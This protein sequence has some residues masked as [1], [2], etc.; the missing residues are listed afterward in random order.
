MSVGSGNG[1]SSGGSE[2]TSDTD[3]S[4]ST[5][6][7]SGFMRRTQQQKWYYGTSTL[8]KSKDG[9]SIGNYG[10]RNAPL[11]EQPHNGYF[12]SGTATKIPGQF[13]RTPNEHYE[14]NTQ[15]DV[16]TVYDKW[17]EKMSVRKLAERWKLPP[18]AVVQWLQGTKNSQMLKCPKRGA[19]SILGS[20]TDFPCRRST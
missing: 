3:S 20:G 6:L 19:T 12:V 11:K 8:F 7:E 16:T 13:I 17:P 18:Y 2:P 5:G 10:A 4:T 14:T 9:K 15:L 1:Q